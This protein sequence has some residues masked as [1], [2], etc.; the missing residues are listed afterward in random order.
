MNKKNASALFIAV[1]MIVSSVAIL[2]TG[3]GSDAQEGGGHHWVLP[4]N[5]WSR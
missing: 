4:P 3:F 1:L 2:S 5:P